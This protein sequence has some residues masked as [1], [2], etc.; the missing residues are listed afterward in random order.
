MS[1]LRKAKMFNYQDGDPINYRIKTYYQIENLDTF[2]QDFSTI[3][4]LLTLFPML[5]S[6]DGDGVA[7]IDN[8]E[9]KKKAWQAYRKGLIKNY[10]VPNENLVVDDGFRSIFNI[11]TQENFDSTDFENLARMHKKFMLVENIAGIALE[12]YIATELKAYGWVWCSGNFIQGTDLIKKNIDGEWEF[13]QIKSRS[14]TENSSSDKIRALIGNRANIR[15]KDWYRLDVSQPEAHTLKWDQLNTIAGS[16]NLSDEGFIEFFREKKEKSLIFNREFVTEIQNLFNIKKIKKQ[17]DANI[18]QI[19]NNILS[20]KTQRVTPLA[21]RWKPLLEK[22]Q[23]LDDQVS[24]IFKLRDALL[25]KQVE[26]QQQI[27][28]LDR[29]ITQKGESLL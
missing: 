19:L 15:I 5:S 28:N 26:L 1:F 7:Y 12:E 11:C 6:L 22:Y 21:N 8:D 18:E 29:E 3:I 23:I 20:K 10:S 27:E 17:I 13:L 25:C 14:N 9:N 2:Y 16:Q 24:D 4:E